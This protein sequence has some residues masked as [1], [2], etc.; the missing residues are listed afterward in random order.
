VRVYVVEINEIVPHPNADRLEILQL[1]RPDPV[2]GA[3]F[4]Q[5]VAGKHYAKGSR[6][7]YLPPG[8]ILPGWLAE[9]MW[10]VGFGN[11]NRWFTIESKVMRGVPSP[12]L[13]AGE[14]YMKDR[15]DEQSVRRYAK[16]REAGATMLTTTDNKEWLRWPMWQSRWKVGDDVGDYIG[17]QCP[18]SSS[19]ERLLVKQE[20]GKEGVAL[21]GPPSPSGFD[22][23]SGL[24]S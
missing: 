23:P 1:A 8:C 4:E 18:D 6:G 3:W 11:A 2:Q 7:V 22:T 15:G 12:G 10:L 17:V 5:I 19:A 9:D 24:S 20:A 21:A 13:F 14:W 16:L